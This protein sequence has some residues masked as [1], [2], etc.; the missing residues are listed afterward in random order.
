MTNTYKEEK[1]IIVAPDIDAEQ[2]FG[3]YCD[4]E[5]GLT[6]YETREDAEAK[7]NELK[8]VDVS[9]WNGYSEEEKR[10]V[11]EENQRLVVRK[12]SVSFTVS[13]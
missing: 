5:M 2:L 12:M 7:L 11:K 1:F 9:K 3:E 4:S 6:I 10:R 13:E 8:A